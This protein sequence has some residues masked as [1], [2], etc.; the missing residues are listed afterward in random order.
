MKNDLLVSLLCN[1]SAHYLTSI[2]A[3]QNNGRSL[4]HLQCICYFYAW[5]INFAV[6]MA[7]K[8]ETEKYKKKFCKCIIALYWFKHLYIY[9]CSHTWSYSTVGIHVLCRYKSCNKWPIIYQFAY[10]CSFISKGWA[11]LL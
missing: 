4:L 5:L 10:I 6:C 11:S 1:F 8:R 9:T 7:E 2:E 3:Y